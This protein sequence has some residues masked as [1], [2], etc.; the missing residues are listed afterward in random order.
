MKKINSL[1]LL[2][3]TFLWSCNQANNKTAS[4]KVEKT[5][6]SEDDNEQIQN[7]IR[8]VYKW[9]EAQEYSNNDMVTDSKDSIYIGFNLD[10]LNLDIEELKATN[11]FSTQ[12]IDNYYKIFTTLD[13]S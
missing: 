9:H 4:V 12:F 8:Q 13:K 5:S 3:I 11:Y 7:L 10:Q 6:S 1:S 2:L